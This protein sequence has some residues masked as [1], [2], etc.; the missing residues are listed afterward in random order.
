VEGASSSIQ[1][2]PNPTGAAESQLYGA[3]CT[4]PSACIGVGTGGNAPL[5]ERWNCTAWS[6]Q[7]IPTVPGASLGAVSCTSPSACI[8]VGMSASGNLAERW[9]GTKWAIQPIPTPVG[10]HGSGLLGI[11]CTSAADCLATGAYYTTSSQA[12]PVLPL[13]ERWNGSTWTILTTPRPAGAVQTFLG[14]VS[15][16]SPSACTATGEQH[17]ASGIVH[18]IAED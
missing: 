16:T 6:R 12:G 17:F 11:S 2:T 3:S 15:C 13:T 7:P 1:R 5:A 10:A 18:T 9:N 8:A 4:S 14:G